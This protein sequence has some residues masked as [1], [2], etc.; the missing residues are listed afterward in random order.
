MMR[1]NETDEFIIPMPEDDVKEW[2]KRREEQL[3]DFLQSRG[4]ST[5]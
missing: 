4:I 3:V 1:E 5:D 2:L